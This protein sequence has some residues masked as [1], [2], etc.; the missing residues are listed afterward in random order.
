[1]TTPPRQSRRSRPVTP[2]DSLIT[3][4]RGIRVFGSDKLG[5]RARMSRFHKDKCKQPRG[6]LSISAEST[7][8]IKIKLKAECCASASS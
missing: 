5:I 2:S 8:S 7:G 3:A 1:M 4:S 6:I